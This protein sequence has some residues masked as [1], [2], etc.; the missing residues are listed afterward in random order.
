MPLVHR[1]HFKAQTSSYQWQRT[2]WISITS[3]VC[4]TAGWIIKD[5]IAPVEAQAVPIRANVLLDVQSGESY[6]AF[7]Q[8]ATAA[9]KAATQGAFNRNTSISDLS[10][11]VTGQNQG[12][13]VQ[14]LTLRANRNQWRSNPNAGRWATYYPTAQS[15]LGLNP[16]PPS[17]AT[18]VI[19]QPG[20]ILQPGQVLQPGQ[21]V[22]ISPIPGGAN[23]SPTPTVVTPGTIAP[24][25][26]GT[27]TQPANGATQ[28]P[29]PTA[30]TSP[31]T[32][33]P[34][35]IAPTTISPATTSPAITFPAT[36]PPPTLA[37]A[38]ANPTFQQ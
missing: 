23:L 36:L 7:M 24:N 3:T 33:A 25:T 34:T 21:S 1:S 31:T 19:V 18:T 5:A 16:P 20:Q 8:R 2:A 12:S 32:I 9:A 13:T 11:V 14:V 29:S 26:P 15:L 35:T 28:L 30:A 37:P 22:Q 38:P 17:V 6:A 4:L 10:V 27:S